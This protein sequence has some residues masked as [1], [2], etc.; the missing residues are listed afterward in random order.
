MIAFIRG[1]V[2]SVEVDHLIVD[3]QDIGY[4]IFLNA[5]DLGSVEI[6]ETLKL[7]TE[8]IV[9]EDE[10]SLYGFIEAKER[11]L[12]NRLR[13]VTTIGAKTALGI[14]SVLNANELI[15]LIINEKA[16]LLTR[17]PGIGKKTA[18]R[19]ILELRDPFFKEYGAVEIAQE[20]LPKEAFG[21]DLELRE[22]LLSLGYSSAEIVKLMKDLDFSLSIEELI[23][24]S[25][26]KLARW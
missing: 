24:M 23:R 20:Q 7:F 19:L 8:M 9:R 2:A 14:L 10:L 25:L 6:G 3:H 12:F 5:R 17:V 11:A 15:E 26:S 16:D 1:E 4:K 18:A 22:A 21:K 13:S